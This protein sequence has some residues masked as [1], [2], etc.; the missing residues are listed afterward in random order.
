MTKTEPEENDPEPVFIALG[1]PVDAGQRRVLELILGMPVP[2]VYS[3]SVAMDCHACGMEIW[4][5]PRQAKVE[6][7]R[8]TCPWCAV[9]L[10]NGAELL[11]VV[12]LGNPEEPK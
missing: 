9:R 4:I 1:F 11:D 3:G 8:P 10:G 6:F 2:G 5:G 12:N 7:C